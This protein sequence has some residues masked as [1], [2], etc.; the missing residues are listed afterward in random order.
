MECT[1]DKMDFQ[2]AGE[3]KYDGDKD[4]A[5][6]VMLTTPEDEVPITL[7]ANQTVGSESQ[8]T[9]CEEATSLA[10]V[11][12]DENSEF[13]SVLPVEKSETVKSDVDETSGNGEDIVEDSEETS[14]KSSGIVAPQKTEEE[15][16]TQKTADSQFESDK[17]NTDNENDAVTEMD[18]EKGVEDEETPETDKVA[19][20]YSETEAAGYCY[21]NYEINSEECNPKCLISTSINEFKKKEGRRKCPTYL[22]GCKWAPDGSCLL[23]NADDDSLRLFNIPSSF[24]SIQDWNSDIPTL[25]SEEWWSTLK[26]KEGGLVYDYCWYPLMSSM[27]PVTSCFLTSSSEAPVHLWDAFTGRLRASYQPFNHL[28]QLMSSYSLAFDSTGENI[29]CGFE[30]SIRIFNITRPGKQCVERSMKQSFPG[31][32]QYGLLSSIAVNPSFKSIYAVGS[33]D[34]TIGLY[35]DDGSV[36]CLLQGQLGGVTHMKF[37]NDGLKLFTGGRKDSRLICWDMR[38]MGEEYQILDRVVATHQRIYFDV[39]PNGRYLISGGTD[40]VVRIWD[41]LKQDDEPILFKGDTDCVNG[42]SLN[43]FVPLLATSSGQRHF[44]EVAD[45]SDEEEMFVKSKSSINRS[46]DIKLWKVP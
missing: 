36:I 24:S 8:D 28:E 19:E 14:E 44:M 6:K 37:S 33:F 1:D 40:G 43:P 35:C 9:A 5:T 25:E 21:W 30:K 2:V 41:M 22:K 31:L 42:I 13:T 11:N 20:E 45:D 12:I 10:S 39:T 15:L 23:S 46:C 18:I 17:V 3:V 29:Y 16:I 4:D 27:D 26:V 34:K 7:I 32:T 38:K